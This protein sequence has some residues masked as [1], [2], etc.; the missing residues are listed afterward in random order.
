M[1]R[2]TSHLPYN[3]RL[4]ALSRDLRR[5]GTLGEALLWKE[6]RARSLG[7]EFHR[8]VPIHEYI[9]DFFCPELRLAI[10]VDGCTHLNEEV[11]AHDLQRQAAL[12]RLG[13]HFLRFQETEVRDNLEGVV[14]WIKTWLETEGPIGSPET[15]P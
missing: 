12:E 1:P 10:E 2:R 15:S 11:Y 8:Q 4:R 3:P 13:V 6:I 5:N 7:P 14:D 9:V